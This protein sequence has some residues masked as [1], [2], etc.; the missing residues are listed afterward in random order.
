[1]KPADM[2][3][4]PDAGASVLIVDDEEVVR[5][6]Y[7]RVLSGAGYRVASAASGFDAVVEAQEH[8]YDL[9]LADLKM[10][11]M[12]G[13]TM[14]RNLVD[15]Q[16]DV[17][18]VTITGFPSRDSAAEAHSLGVEQ[19]LTKPLSPDQLLNATEQA[20]LPTRQAV[21]PLAAGAGSLPV[22]LAAPVPLAP[23]VA[24]EVVADVEAKVEGFRSFLH[25]LGRVLAAPFIG[26]AYVVF[27]PL[28]GFGV[29]FSELGKSLWSVVRKR[30]TES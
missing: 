14:I 22:T 1:M 19:Y 10:P 18:V 4:S 23:R 8:A 25:G 2:K 24:E 17:R 30:E 27:L 12:D 7:E 11:G 15:L 16:P 28:A 6:S 26:M 3:S 20:L 29:I 13:L 5:R 9:V 21:I